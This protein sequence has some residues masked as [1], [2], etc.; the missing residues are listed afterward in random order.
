ME[1]RIL[2]RTGVRISAL[3]LGTMSFGA[4]AD[5]AEAAAIYRRCREVG[6]NGFD[7]ANVYAGGRS[8]E[9]LG[10]LIAPERDAVFVTSKVGF[11]A[12]DGVNDRG[13]SRRHIRQAVEQS[14]R[15]LRT[16]HLDLL[17]VHTYD[18][19]VAIDE[20]LRALDDLVRRGEVLYFGASNWAAWQIALALGRSAAEGW[21]RFSC[22][23]PMYNLVKRQAEVELLPL[24]EAQAL[25]VLT[26][27]PLG[28]GLL[29]GKYGVGRRPPAG[30]LVENQMYGTRYGEGA[31]YEVADRL[32][33]RAKAHGVHP[34]ALAVAWAAAHP[35]VTAPI[36]GARTLAQLEG[37]L[38]AVE[39]EMTSELY[40]E[41]SALSPAPPPATD[42]SEERE[43]VRYGG[44]HE[45]E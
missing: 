13:L 19:D 11:P 6:I 42:R 4:A 34:A 27:S 14:L 45:R 23:Q 15:R 40:R 16:D 31:Y 29:S 43:G 8:E 25:G 10:R 35:A 44:I 26:Y 5:A 12:G 24:A 3:C 9:I 33:E 32:A 37:S 18:A 36:I 28:G 1:Y 20:T 41:I 7:S 38:G 39:I 17:F 22:I 2:G 30:R 21:S